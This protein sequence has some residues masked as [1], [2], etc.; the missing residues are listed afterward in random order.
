M[1]RTRYYAVPIARLLTLLAEAGFVDVERRDDAAVA[2]QDAVG[3]L[4]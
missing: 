1:L 2:G 4:D 3:A